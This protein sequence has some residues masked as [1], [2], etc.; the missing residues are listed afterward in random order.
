[1]E[2]FRCDGV[3]GAV[4]V[5]GVSAGAPG[6]ASS[7]GSTRALRGGSR[8]ARARPVVGVALLRFLVHVR[9]GLV[10]L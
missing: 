5:L 4:G 2:A 9:C 6:A 8:Q 3:G 10:H 1:M 7:G